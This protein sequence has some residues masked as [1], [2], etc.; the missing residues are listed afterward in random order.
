AVSR[1]IQPVLRGVDVSLDTGE[2]CAVMGV[3]GAG[4]TTVLRTV[5]ALQSFSGGSIDVDGFALKPGPVPP[6]SQLRE[7]R[8]RVGVVFQC[9]AL[10]EHLTVLEN[11]MLAPVHA[12]K[13]SPA[14][15]RDVAHKLLE[16]LGV[17]ARH[18]AYP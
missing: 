7:L 11:V 2:I 1:G 16:E 17:V 8:K 3:S 5:A 12:L 15:A 10:F 18:A 4:K 6:E 9:H 14:K 13:W